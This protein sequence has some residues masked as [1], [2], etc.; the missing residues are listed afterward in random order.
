MDEHTPAYHVD[1]D[2]RD[3]W[4]VYDANDQLICACGTRTNAERYAVM[5]NQAF[6]RGYKTGYREA[7]RLLRGA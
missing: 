1:S 4:G 7:K 3:D 6:K 5:L 2:E